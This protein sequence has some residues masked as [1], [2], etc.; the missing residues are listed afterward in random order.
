[1]TGPVVTGDG[2][3][4]E[5]GPVLGSALGPLLGRTTPRTSSANTSGRAR[6]SCE[7]PPTDPISP[8]LFTLADADELLATRGLRTPFLRIAK[9]GAVQAES[10]FTRGAGAGAGI[11]DQVDPDRVAGLLADGCTVV[12]QG[13][14]RIWPAVV[15]FTPDPHRR[16]RPP[17][18]GQRVPD[19]AERA[20]VRAA[21]RHP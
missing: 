9:D 1:M 8:V 4:G 21:L 20:R 12:F 3:G 10:T 15:D 5:A 14:H 19:A 2:L 6:R 16:A 13:L 18:A 17:G 7:R 11:R